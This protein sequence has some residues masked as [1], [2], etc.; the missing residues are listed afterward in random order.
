DPA[1][2]W[3]ET[4]GGLLGHHVGALAP[5]ERAGRVF[6]GCQYE[7]GLGVSDE[8]GASWRPC[9]EGWEGGRIQSLALQQGGEDVGMWLGTEPP[10]L[11]RSDDLGESW[12]ARP[13][14]LKVHNND[15]WTFPPP[16]HVAHV[17]N[18]S[19]HPERPDDI[20]ICIEQ[21]ALLHSPDAGENWDEVTG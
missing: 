11:Y 2:A 9:N 10:M 14:M 6:A 13:G 4:G 3:R 12:R 19:F 15:K 1:G 16:P 18:I 17:K 21:G 8:Q 5:D 20:F 7:G